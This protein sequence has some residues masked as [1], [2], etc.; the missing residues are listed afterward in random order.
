MSHDPP[1]AGQIITADRIDKLDTQG[2]YTPVLTAATTNPDLG[3][4]FSTGHWQRNGHLFNVW[5]EIEIGETGVD[6]GGSSW[7]VSLPFL[8]DLTFH[9]AGALAGAP[10]RIGGFK[11]R[12]LSKGGAALLYQDSNGENLGG[13]VILYEG[14]EAT[15]I[16]GADFTINAQLLINCSYVADPADL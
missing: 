1:L 16:G 13:Y 5:I 6:F 2:A 9:R 8:A 11:T 4:G 14:D 7:R 12:S 15:S 3:D 10:S